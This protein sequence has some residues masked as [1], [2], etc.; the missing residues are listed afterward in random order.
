MDYMKDGEFV[1]E[2]VIDDLFYDE[3]G[4]YIMENADSSEVAICNG[5]SLLMYMEQGYL[6]NEFLESVGIVEV[7]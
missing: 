6:W 2:S 1:S 4:S 3:Y 7:E 5:D